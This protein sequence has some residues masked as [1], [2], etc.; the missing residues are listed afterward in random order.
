MQVNTRWL[1]P[2][3]RLLALSE[4]AERERLV[5]DACFHTAA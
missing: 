1:A 4:A 5:G 2:I 3:A